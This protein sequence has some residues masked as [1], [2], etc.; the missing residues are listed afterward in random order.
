MVY[1]VSETVHWIV[2]IFVIL[3]TIIIITR[4]V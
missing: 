3:T 1:A 4:G 2:D